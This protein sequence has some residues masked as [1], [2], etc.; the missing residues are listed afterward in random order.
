V[1]GN[2]PLLSTDGWRGCAGT[3]TRMCPRDSS[4]WGISSSPCASCLLRRLG[5]HRFC[6]RG[7]GWVC[8]RCGM[9]GGICRAGVLRGWLWAAVPVVRLCV[10]GIL[11]RDLWRAWRHSGGLWCVGGVGVSVGVG[12]SVLG[13]VGSVVLTGAIGGKPLWADSTTAVRRRCGSPMVGETKIFEIIGERSGRHVGS[14]FHRVQQSHTIKSRLF[15]KNL[16][17]HSIHAIRKGNSDPAV[18]DHR[19]SLRHNPN[20]PDHR[21]SCLRPMDHKNIGINASPMR[22]NPLNG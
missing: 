18:A 9:A 13:V 20:L 16:S 8:G 21:S 15:I 11:R 14:C 6:S 19:N 12:W 2:V 22:P 4:C 1:G 17:K 10:V 5:R 3:S 7:Y